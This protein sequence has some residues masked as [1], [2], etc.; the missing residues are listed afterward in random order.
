M[1]I[2]KIDFFWRFNEPNKPPEPLD[3]TIP[4]VR[5]LKMRN[6]RNSLQIWIQKL[7]DLLFLGTSN[8]SKVPIYPGKVSTCQDVCQIQEKIIFLPNRIKKNKSFSPRV[9]VLQEWIVRGESSLFVFSCTTIAIVNI[10]A[11]K[12]VSV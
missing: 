9:H 4:C 7:Q 12:K 10:K 3:A 6:L 1:H 11:S 2:E 8:Q 5:I